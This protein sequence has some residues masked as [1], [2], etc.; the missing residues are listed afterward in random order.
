MI[1]AIIDFPCDSFAEYVVQTLYGEYD[2][3]RHTKF[4][5]ILQ[6]HCDGDYKIL[7]SYF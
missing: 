2:N 7:L 1:A 6:I 3:T 5:Y 4:V